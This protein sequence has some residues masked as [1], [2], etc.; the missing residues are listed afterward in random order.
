MPNFLTLDRI[1][2][3][4]KTVLLRADLNVP[5]KDGSVTDT[6]RLE[7]LIPTLTDL[8]KVKA[9]IV[10]LSHLGRPDGKKNEKYSLRPVAAALE[11]IWGRP[12][13]FAEDCVGKIASDAIAKLPFGDVLV[14]ENT[15]FYEGE[16]KNDP[17][18]AGQLAALGNAYVNDAFSAAHRAHASTEGMAKFMPRAAGRLMQAE[19][20]ALDKALGTPVHPVAAIVGGSKVSTKLDLLQNL[21]LRVDYLILGGG[22]ANTFLA[23][24]GVNVGKSLH[25]PD[26]L[27]TARGIATRAAARTCHIILPKDV[28]VAAELKANVATKTVALDRIPVDG[29]ILDIGPQ[30]VK[31]IG[32]AL[33]NCKTV[34]WNGPLGAFETPPFD[35]AT[36]AVAKIVSKLTKEGYILSVAGGG[37]TVSA[38]AHAGVMD[39][40]SY[41]ST[42]GGAFL[43]WMEGKKLPGVVALAGKG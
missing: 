1:N 31:E 25:E 43:E 34:I 7:R 8:S 6:T 4:G 11:K 30:S 15:R 24:K 3:S 14:L 35:Q 13:A 39:D 33:Q 28:V 23:A 32:N 21:I 5:M 19:L 12:V 18:F 38:L 29:M 41:V 36:T 10:I 20:E 42:A 37:D 2:F 40:L 17:V 16:E 27:N 22:M 26:M 9:K